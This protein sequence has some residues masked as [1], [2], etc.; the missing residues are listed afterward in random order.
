[1]TSAA[2]FQAGPNF[3]PTQ[4]SDGE[5]CMNPDIISLVVFICLISAVLLGR[6]LRG[7]LPEHH[8]SPDSRDV[9]KLAMGLV[10]TM[11]ALLLGLLVTSAKSTYDTT[12]TEVIQMAAKATFLDRLL[13][14]YGPE[15][16]D[17]RA[18]FREAMV[19]AVQQIWPSDK[20]RPASL[21]P[22]QKQGTAIFAAIEKLAPRD[23]M[24]RSLKS[25]AVSLAIELGQ[26]RSLLAAQEVTSISRPLLI[27]V[28][29]WLVIIFL[30]FSLLAPPNPTAALALTASALSVAGAM[31]LIME[32]DRPFDGLIRISSEPMLHALGSLPK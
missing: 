10:A 26:L 25:Q 24:Q 4:L 5:S 30:G 9:V 31:F 29:C 20:N 19:N 32:L 16:A 14:A 17:A 12:R 13:A 8:L 7:L 28:V 15:A 21:G 6:T 22:D 27:V 23:D 11:S 1:M 2:R 18:L 3:T